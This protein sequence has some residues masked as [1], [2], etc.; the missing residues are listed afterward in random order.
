MEPNCFC[1]HFCPCGFDEDEEDKP[2]KIPRACLAIYPTYEW[3][4]PKEISSKDEELERI[5]G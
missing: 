4:Q 2:F 3:I 5:L 1:D